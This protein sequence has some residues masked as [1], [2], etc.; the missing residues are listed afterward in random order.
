LLG[1]DL[2]GRALE[3]TFHKTK[4]TRVEAASPFFLKHGIIFSMDKP[5]LHY[6]VSLTVLTLMLALGVKHRRTGSRRCRTRAVSPISVF[7][8]PTQPYFDRTWALPD[9]VEVK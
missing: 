7:Y 2:R 5:I 8:G 1:R 4:A 3:G 6:F 9:I